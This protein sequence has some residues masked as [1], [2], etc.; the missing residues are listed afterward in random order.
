MNEEVEEEELCM[1]SLSSASHPQDL[2]TE[3]RA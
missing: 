2:T 3:Q 1:H